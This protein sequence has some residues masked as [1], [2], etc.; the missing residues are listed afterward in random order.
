MTS[1]HISFRHTNAQ[2][3]T[4]KSAAVS[5]FLKQGSRCAHC[6]TI[7]ISGARS[8]CAH[9]GAWFG[10]CGDAGDR[11]FGH[12]WTEGERACD[13][14]GTAASDE[15]TPQV[16]LPHPGSMPYP[17]H[18]A[19]QRSDAHQHAFTN[20]SG[21]LSDAGVTDFAR[22]AGFAPVFVCLWILFIILKL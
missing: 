11:R 2:I 21:S 7:T 9:G 14:F 20:P 16:M 6:A 15:S 3:P 4:E 8:C 18:V 12:T 19:R 13:G 10:I 1:A 22:C 5:L 17:L